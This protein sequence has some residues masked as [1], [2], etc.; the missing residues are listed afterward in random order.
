MKRVFVARHGEWDLRD[1]RLIPEGVSN[2]RALSGKLPSFVLV[3][4]STARRTAE[5]ADILSGY[6][7]RQGDDNKLLP[8]Q[9]DTLACAP[10]IPREF[11]PQ[12]DKERT[13]HA[14]GVAGVVFEIPEAQTSLRIAGKA[15]SMLVKQALD[16]MQDGQ[17]ALI[18]THDGTMV[19]AERILTNTP[20]DTPLDHSYGPLDGFV[21]D[22]Q[23]QVS[24]LQS[25]LAD[26]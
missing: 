26:E 12:I 5:T 13:A 25:H 21:V 16:T 22:D 2:A 11:K 17:D 14:L 10:K 19:A 23:L 4:A 1:D 3:Y 7:A 18:V 15:L 20:M 8:A 6:S 24:P 9:V